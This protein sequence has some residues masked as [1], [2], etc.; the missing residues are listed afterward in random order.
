MRAYECVKSNHATTTAN[1]TINAS[2][3]TP[4]RSVSDSAPASMSAARVKI[5]T[6][7]T[8]ISATTARVMP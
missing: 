3:A 4:K 5:L 2:R 1:G 8:K 7:T 6:A